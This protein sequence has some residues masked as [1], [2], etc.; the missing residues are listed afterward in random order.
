MPASRS[1]FVISIG[2]LKAAC[3]NSSFLPLDDIV[4]MNNS[5]ISSQSCFIALFWKPVVAII[6]EWIPN[7]PLVDH[8]IIPAPSCL[9]SSP[10]LLP[11]ISSLRVLNWLNRKYLLLPVILPSKSLISVI[12]PSV[13]TE[14]IT[15][16]KSWIACK[17][18]PIIPL[19]N[20]VIQEASKGLESLC[21]G[22]LIISL[23]LLS[24]R[25]LSPIPL[26]NDP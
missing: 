25:F 4:L 17:H 14:I 13:V 19:I 10:E 18:S 23:V 26:T 6:L 20:P 16:S 5:T 2:P 22:N 3:M 24:N 11:E 1:G 9:I 21:A 12:K 15:P 8:V 7:W